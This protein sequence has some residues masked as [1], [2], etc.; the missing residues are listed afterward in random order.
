[1]NK[2]FAIVGA[3]FCGLSIALN[4]LKAGHS[5]TLFDK[6]PIGSNTSSA[7]SGLCHPFPGFLARTAQFEKE[8]RCATVAQI[9][10]VQEFAKVPL[11]TARRLLR[12]AMNEKQQKRFEQLAQERDDFT[13]ATELLPFIKSGMQAYWIE[14]GMAIESRAYIV[15]L[16]DMCTS[17][18]MKFEQK[19]IA[20]LSDLDQFDHIVLALGA[21][22]DSLID[23]GNRGFNRVKGQVLV[24]QYS[25]EVP[26]TIG[27]GYIAKSS[28]TGHYHMGSTYEHQFESDEPNLEVAKELILGKAS[29]YLKEA[30]Q[31]EVSGVKSGVR[32]S[33]KNNPLPF[34]ESISSRVTILTGMGSRGLL[35]H[36]YFAKQLALKLN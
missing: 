8:G 10:E 35:Y 13:K 1:M 36:A 31:F 5:V 15:A 20:K 6:N 11:I 28:E 21:D 19:A 14:S 17:L 34:M 24:G 4:L 23:L 26:A 22:S 29:S 16:F 9:K 7:A 2:H 27:K 3:G 18:G 12:V 30:N 32:Y 25:Q 33:R